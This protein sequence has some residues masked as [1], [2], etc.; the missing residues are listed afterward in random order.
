[1]DIDK[2][3]KT[4]ST[5]FVL[6]L[7]YNGAT[8][9]DVWFDNFINCYITE[10]D[11]PNPEN[12]LIIEYDNDVVRFRVNKDRL[13][14]YNKIRRGE[15][16]LLSDEAKQRILHF[17]QEDETSLM[18]SVLYKT[19]KILDYWSKITGNQVY[20]SESKEYWPK[21]N[22][23]NETKG[24]STLYNAYNFNLIK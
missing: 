12:S 20:P 17:W 1:M 13:D 6:P 4:K 10:H 2:I 14:D 8:Y 3:K 19:E 22:S 16:S 11:K 18:Y 9:K 23:L 24:L 15:Y 5:I 21:F 7:L